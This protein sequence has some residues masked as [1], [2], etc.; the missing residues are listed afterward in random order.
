MIYTMEKNLGKSMRWLQIWIRAQRINSKTI[1]FQQKVHPPPPEDKIPV[2]GWCFPEL[3]IVLALNSAWILGLHYSRQGS[4][5]EYLGREVSETQDSFYLPPSTQKILAPVAR[6]L[7][8]LF[9]CQNPSTLPQK[10]LIWS[11]LWAMCVND[12]LPL[13]IMSEPFHG[14]YSENR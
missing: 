13:V 7:R 9:L 10:E 14:T 4:S 2:E 11:C 12:I 6:Q 5:A 1:Y 3:G 8:P